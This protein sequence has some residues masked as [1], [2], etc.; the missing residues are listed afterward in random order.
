MSFKTGMTLKVT[1]VVKSDPRRFSI[2]VGHSVE[3]IALH[4][5]V[6]FK[7]LSDVLTIVLNSKK[8][9]SWQHE[10]REHDFP[11]EA[12]KE[13][14]VSILFS[15]DDFDIYLPDGHKVQ[16]PNRPGCKNYS[17]LF[18]GG[19]AKIQEISVKPSN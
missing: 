6:R 9:N 19:D 10:K 5:D 13:F 3:S 4:F 7:H 17:Y 18:F 15:G 2:N 1:G 8:N 12:E 16:F 11:F 14:E